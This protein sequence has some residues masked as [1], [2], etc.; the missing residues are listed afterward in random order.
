MRFRRY[1]R[2]LCGCIMLREQCQDTAFDESEQDHVP[3]CLCLDC[4]CR[5]Q[6]EGKSC[7]SAHR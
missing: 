3:S 5:E 1:L 6:G 4:G 7:G 2:P